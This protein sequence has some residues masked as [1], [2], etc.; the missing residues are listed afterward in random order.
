[1]AALLTLPLG[2]TLGSGVAAA[3]SKNVAVIFV[4]SKRK[5][6][7]FGEDMTDDQTVTL[8]GTNREVI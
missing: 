6:P 8:E 3:D 5:E 7:L 4:T 2:L 1:L